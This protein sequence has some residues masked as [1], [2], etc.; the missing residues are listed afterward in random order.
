MHTSHP[1]K[2][3]CILCIIFSIVFSCKKDTPK[4]QNPTSKPETL[5]K[6]LPETHTGITFNNKIAEDA[7]NFFLVYNYAYNG[8]GVA[9]GDIN[10]D[11]L[12]D[13]FFTGN[14][15]SNR[16]YLNKGDFKFEDITKSAGVTSKKGWDNGVVMAD[17]NG[18]T[19]LDIYVCRGGRKDADKERANLL[20]INNGDNTF[21]EKAET[22]N[23]ADKGYSMI[24][25]F[26]DM[27]N[28]NDLDLFVTNR[29][30]QFFLSH[31]AVEKGKK[32]QSDL[33][34]DKLY[35]NI[36]GTFKEVS[37][38]AG[39]NNTFA[40]G[41]GIATSDINN[42]GHSDIYVANDYFESDYFFKNNGNKTFTQSI[43]TLSNHVAF[44]G[45]GIDV[46]DFN[47]DG[48]ED[49]MELDMTSSDHVRAKTTMASMNVAAYYRILEQGNHHQYMHNMLQLNNGNG[50]FSEISQYAGVAK[51][52]WSW[53]C[54]G[55]DFDNDGYRDLF[56]TNGFRRDIFDKDATAKVTQY[57]KSE[58]KR[59][60]SKNE[61]VTHIVNLFNENKIH[62]YI[63]KNDGNLKFSNQVKNW[64]ME[65]ISFSNGAAV[66]DLD[67]D[68]DLDL[69]VNN[70]N[71]PAF[72]YQNK[73]ET[74]KHNFLNVQLKGPKNNTYGL[75]A[76]ITLY[77]PSGKQY[78]ELKTVR[79]YLSSV[80]P[81]T[82]FGLG[83]TNTVD[84]ITVA[85]P[86]YKT[87]TIT[88]NISLNTTLNIAYTAAIPTDI[89]KEILETPIFNN[90][91]HKAF[92]KHPFKHIEN[93][94][95]DFKNQVLLPH[96]LST[97]GPCIAVAD[98]NND[99]L[100]DFFAGGAAG[101][102][103]AIY[104]QNRNKTFTKTNAIPLKKDASYE[105]TS[106]IFF[107]ANNDNHL[108]LY[109]VSGGSAYN[110]HSKNYQD[111]LYINNGK[112]KF[113]KTT[114]L[115]IITASG[116]SVT[117]LDF[118]ADGDLDLF[119]G[120]RHVPNNYPNSPQSYLLEN[121]KEGFK[122]VTQQKA[123]AIERIGMVTDAVWTDIDNDS[124]NELF[125]VGEW[126]P[127]RAFNFTNGKL[128]EKKLPQLKHTN[129]WW[130]TIS[131]KDIDN[132]GYIDLVAGNLG[133]NYKFKASKEKP[134]YIFASDYDKNGTNDI[135]LAKNYKNKIVPVRGK[136]CSSQ[137]MP[138]LS[139]KFKTYNAFANADLGSIINDK[140][141]ST[142]KHKA[143]MFKSVILKNTKG[144]LQIKALP[145]E[146]QFSAVQGILLDDY[147]GNSTTDIVIA[148]NKFNSEIETTRADAS[149]GALIQQD[150]IGNLQTI[151]LPKSG[152]FLPY[153]VKTICPI[154]LGS[155]NN[156]SKGV[157]VGVNDGELQ[158]LEATSK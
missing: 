139:K 32:A 138:I 148:G 14:Q 72:V 62:N 126:M 76:K 67:N 10:N 152:V 111:R 110:E 7:N 34:R 28:D 65:N 155:K 156:S 129:G 57:L 102:T 61:N 150:T 90:I 145:Y 37:Q 41:L 96:K 2:H 117:A 86:D 147:T 151:P 120:G 132:D 22:Y 84:S 158:L 36:N 42:D 141:L 87:T 124:T 97:E 60:R 40:Y 56:I 25:S 3:L 153:N 11:G 74:L 77:T 13:I 91:T 19:Y 83:K 64:G 1:L 4:P 93:S 58:E 134:F 119:V 122:D 135:F 105:D 45:M 35:E 73:A 137:Q 107:D 128:T 99:G 51:T 20:Y 30:R 26:F 9:I 18:D 49:I 39:I 6:L 50:F 130:N 52:D 143:Y 144:N 15:V 149:V 12:N 8:G 81:T 68:G 103:G 27:D 113:T 104:I 157:L 133:E 69:V 29:P 16:L 24:A 80:A 115:P 38:I 108:D 48:Y 53:S 66:A 79:G 46:V 21:T 136:E 5:F 94:F 118:D 95:D 123:K 85:W 154:T 121:T 109:V 75:G 127:I 63:Y 88:K 89:N 92:S 78:H 100:D 114:T 17:V 59:K 71:D 101:Q 44:Y 70:I 23:I 33:H 125:V 43:N 142:E 106:A 31:D 131:A 98:I 55:S 146:A 112:G 54:L 82:H 140:N 47:N 116:G